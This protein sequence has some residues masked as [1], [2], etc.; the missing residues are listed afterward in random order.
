[1]GNKALDINAY[2]TG[3]VSLPGTFTTGYRRDLHLAR[4]IIQKRRHLRHRDKLL[5]NQY[6]TSQIG[7]TC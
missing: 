1:M 5:R 2:V 6:A 7:D 3:E 4:E